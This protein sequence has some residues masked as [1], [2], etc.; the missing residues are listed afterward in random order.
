MADV[1]QQRLMR[2]ER[3]FVGTGTN[4]FNREATFYKIIRLLSNRCHFRS[5]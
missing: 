5:L 2:V 4:I 3:Q 1:M